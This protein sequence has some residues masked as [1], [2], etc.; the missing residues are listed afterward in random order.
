MSNSIDSL[1]VILIIMAFWSFS[2]TALT[3]ALPVDALEYVS[4]FTG[5]SA[6]FD[7]EELGQELTDSMTQQT[8][9]PVVD[10]GA[11]VF[12][13]GNI[14]LDFMLNFAFAIPEMLGLFIAGLCTI[15]NL[16]AYLVQLVQL[17]AS[18]TITALYMIGLIQLITSI[19]SG[20]SII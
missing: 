9:I 3:Y 2:I 14:L 7:I 20:N 17:M 13:S 18:V 12:Y 5:S 10:M 15:L 6:S 19:R 4:I 16:D 1:K 11:L 8:N